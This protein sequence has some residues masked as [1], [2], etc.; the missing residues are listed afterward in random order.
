MEKKTSRVCRYTI[1]NIVYSDGT[2]SMRRKN[3]GFSGI[4]L[5]GILEMTQLEIIQEIAGKLKPDV[6]TREVVVDKEIRKT[7]KLPKKPIRPLTRYEVL[8]RAKGHRQLFCLTVKDNPFEHIDKGD[9]GKFPY[10]RHKKPAESD[11]TEWFKTEKQLLAYC[12]QNSI[13]PK[14]IEYGN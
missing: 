12:E 9:Y 6:I 14:K 13:T 11:Y 8:L 4:E 10:E 1:E 2:A 3:E 5:L 7:N